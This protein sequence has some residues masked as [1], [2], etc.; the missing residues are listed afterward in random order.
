MN[1]IFL[2]WIIGIMASIVVGTLFYFIYSKQKEKQEPENQPILENYLPQYSDGHTDG[3]VDEIKIGEK[4]IGISFY[5]RD[6]NYI[7]E[8]KKNKHF[9]IK[10]YTIFY[11][12]NQIDF[13]PQGTFSMH[14]NK[15]KG[16]PSDISLLPD[17][18]KDTPQGK[19]IMQT[20][21]KNNELKDE[22]E[23]M[24]KRM[25]ALKKVAEETYGGEIFM[26]HIETTKEILKDKDTI[27]KRETEHKIE[28]KK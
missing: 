12:K 19:I 16:Y 28:E 7:R 8:L 9:K 11:D 10:R 20:I 13:I 18:L 24:S 23:L 22:S 1:L 14:R 15:I 27:V 21:E 26:K 17:Y 2:Y 3:I 6:I 25:I 5:P 4:R